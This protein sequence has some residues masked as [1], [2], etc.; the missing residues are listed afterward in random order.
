MGDKRNK[1]CN[2]K[3]KNFEKNIQYWIILC[4]LSTFVPYSNVYTCINPWIPPTFYSNE[5]A[6]ILYS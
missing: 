2:I 3:L 1:V 4:F 6:E 5:D